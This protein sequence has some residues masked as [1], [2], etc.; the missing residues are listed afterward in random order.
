M[1]KAV[2]SVFSILLL[3]AFAFPQ[4]YSGKARMVGYVYDQEGNP[5]EGVTVKLYS[6]R[7]EGGFELKTNKSGKWVA[8]GIRGGEWEI[9]F[10][11]AGY[12]PK[13]ITVDV[14]SF[15]N[16]PDIEVTLDETEG[17]VITEEMKEK[18]SSGNKL[19]DEGNYEQAVQAYQKLLEENP[20][21]Y[22]INKNIGNC[23]FQM[24][25]YDK[26]VES[27]Q[28]ILDEDPENTEAVLLIGKAYENKGDEEKALEWYRK[29]KFEE[30]NDPIVLY[31]IGT[32][33]YN[34][35]NYEEALKYY[36]R[37]VELKEDFLD[38]I[39]QLGLTYLTLEKN[40]EAVDQFEKYLE[41]DPDSERADQVKDFL[42]YLR[43]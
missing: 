18:L 4:A 10:E 31:N 23:Y 5:I 32:R 29:V 39:Y 21:V 30:I 34:M 27:Y 19:F 3:V 16:N 8:M 41:I 13:G 17:I 15:G 14:S 33:L 37:S 1:K 20:D 26:A 9:D 7:A 2:V 24:E 36:Q 35:A 38:S 42:S 43:R 6:V 22:V 28:K 40:Q 11:K 12:M 25:Q